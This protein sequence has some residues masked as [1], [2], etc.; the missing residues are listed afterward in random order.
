MKTGKDE[1]KEKRNGRIEHRERERKGKTTSKTN[2]WR[3]SEDRGGNGLERQRDSVGKRSHRD[4]VQKEQNR[5][6]AQIKRAQ[7]S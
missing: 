6:G 7:D 3:E 2:Q 1:A 5:A 4:I